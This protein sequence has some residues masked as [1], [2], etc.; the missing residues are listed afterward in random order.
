MTDEKEIKPAEIQDEALNEAQG[1]LRVSRTG[2]RVPNSPL[3]NLA[4]KGGVSGAQNSPNLG[5]RMK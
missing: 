4:D 2:I 3:E 5:K 1:G